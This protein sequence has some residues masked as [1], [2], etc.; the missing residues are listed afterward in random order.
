MNSRIIRHIIWFI[1]LVLTQVFI[2]NNIN[3]GGYINP[4]IYVL[5]ILLLPVDMSKS[6]LLVLAFAMG[7]TIDFFGNTLGLHAAATVLLAFAKPGVI[8]LFFSNIEFS[9]NEEPGLK[10]LKF[11]GFF[12]YAFVLV[13]I[14]NFT[15]FMLEIFTGSTRRRPQIKRMIGG[16]GLAV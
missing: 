2:L 5:F 9:A 7:L 14:H 1:F 16:L 15:L 8:N 4:Y 3:I 6:L 10:R 11:A 13:F 12:K